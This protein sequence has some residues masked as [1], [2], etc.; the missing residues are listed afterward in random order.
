MTLLLESGADRRQGDAQG[1]TALHLG[2]INGSAE[3]VRAICRRGAD[4]DGD[5]GGTG[6]REEEEV[7]VV[8]VVEAAD[9]EGRTALHMAAQEDEEEV[10][11]VLVACGASVYAADKQ[12]GG[13][14]R[15]KKKEEICNVLLSP[16]ISF[17]GESPLHNSA[18]KDSS[19]AASLLLSNGAHPRQRDCSGATPLHEACMSG[20]SQGSPPFLGSLRRQDGRRRRQRVHRHAPRGGGESRGAGGHA[21]KGGSRDGLEVNAIFFFFFFFL[22]RLESS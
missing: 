5:G 12:G 16:S 2:T 3:A 10:V 4:R 1:C 8:V 13:N 14:T 19:S 7:V 6:R 17:T 22:G 9:L 20:E 18:K 11:A 21:D 15:K